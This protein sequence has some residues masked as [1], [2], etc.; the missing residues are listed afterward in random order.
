MDS[1]AVDPIHKSYLH[2]R[3]KSHQREVVSRVSAVGHGNSI[4]LLELVMASSRSSA[5]SAD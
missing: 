5:R 2:V 1:I 4:Y 3:G